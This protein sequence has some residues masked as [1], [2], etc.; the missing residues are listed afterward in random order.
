MNQIIIVGEH[1][2]HRSGTDVTYAEK[3]YMGFIIGARMD[4]NHKRDDANK[5]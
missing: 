3:Y 4:R 5:C 2:Y 1:N